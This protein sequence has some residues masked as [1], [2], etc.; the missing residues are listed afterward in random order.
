MARILQLPIKSVEI[1]VKGLGSM[2]TGTTGSAIACIK[3]RFN[4]FQKELDVLLVPEIP[5]KL[6][7]IHIDRTS[8]NIPSNLKLADPEF[9]IPSEVDALLGVKL[10]YQLLC[11]GQRKIKGHSAVLQKTHLGWIVAGEINSNTRSR[12]I[13]CNFLQTANRL[14]QEEQA[15]EKHFIENVKREHNGR[16]IVKLPFRENK[17]MLGNSHKTVLRRFHALEDRLAKYS[18][19][20]ANYTEFMN[21]YIEL[22]HMSEVQEHTRPQ[23]GVF[24][25]NHAVIKGD[26]LTTKTRVVFDGSAKTSSSVSLND[27]LMVAPTIQDNLFSIYTRFRSL[28]YAFTADL[29]KMYRQIRID[30]EDS[31]YQKILWQDSPSKP[32]KIYNLKTVTYG[33]A[34]APFLVTRV[35]AQLAHDE[36]HTFPRAAQIPARDFYVDDFASGAA[37]FVEA[38]TLRDELVQ[39]VQKGGFTLRKWASN[40]PRLTPDLS[41]RSETE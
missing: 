11:V 14:D 8:I 41:E 30:P 35:L 5:S 39:L 6:P 3:S 4:R 18:T 17:S 7:S 40:D 27:T 9:Y 38:S 34:S 16:Y 33:T 31:M 24:L 37:T 28:P 2:S 1:P 36:C 29:V 21:E 22:D 26:S 12:E 15:C 23:E 10:Y 19:T 32:L 25:P 20:K 13:K